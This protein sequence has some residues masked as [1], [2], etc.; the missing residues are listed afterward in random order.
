MNLSRREVLAAVGTVAAGS[1]AASAT[2]L[3]WPSPAFAASGA[4]DVAGKITVGY[5][6]W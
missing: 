2:T 4:G 6:G 3:L 5:Q 1:A